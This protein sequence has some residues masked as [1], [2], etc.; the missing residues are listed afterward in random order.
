M[1]IPPYMEVHPV[2]GRDDSGVRRLREVLN[3]GA[4]YTTTIMPVL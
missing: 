3:E 1:A 4:V 2:K